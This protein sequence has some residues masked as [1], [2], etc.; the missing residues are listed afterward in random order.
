MATI[1]LGDGLGS[2]GLCFCPGKKQLKS[3]TGPWHRDL[4]AIAHWNAPA[5]VTLVEQFELNDLNVPHLGQVIERHMEWLH[6]HV[7]D[8]SVPD[9]EFEKAW[10]T[11]ASIRATLHSQV[12]GPHP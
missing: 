4:Q 9:A 1:D 11:G 2:L 8:V 3:T 6:L 12:C 10:I 7:V 5:V